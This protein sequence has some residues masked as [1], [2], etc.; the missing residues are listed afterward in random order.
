M[1]PVGLFVILSFVP[2]VLAG[3]GIVLLLVPLIRQPAHRRRALGV[4]ALAAIA[5][6]SI[7]IG[8]KLLDEIVCAER[9]YHES[10][11]RRGPDLESRELGDPASPSTRRRP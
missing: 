7:C 3:V 1:S 6:P 8:Q 2:A 9:V 10:R 11:D 5:V 4:L